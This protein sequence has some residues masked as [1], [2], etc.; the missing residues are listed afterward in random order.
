MTDIRELLASNL[1]KL[2]ASRDWSQ[3]KLAEKAKTST[4]YIGMI[5]TKI[6]YPSS[7]M[8]HRLA[9]AFNI[10]PAELFYKNL[11]PE[12]T[13]KN[14]KKAVIVDFGEEICNMINLLVAE[15]SKNIEESKKSTEN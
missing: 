9:N 10:D 1:K 6:K 14:A 12:T 15:K 2:R 4:Q 3:A 7:S 5:E 13:M 8:V 11:D